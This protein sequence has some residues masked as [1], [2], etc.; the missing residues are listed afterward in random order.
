MGITHVL[1]GEEWLPSLPLH[2]DLYAHLNLTP[3]DFAHIPILLNPDGSKMSKRNGDVRVV[4]YIVSC[5]SLPLSFFRVIS[6]FIALF[7][8]YSAVVGNLKLS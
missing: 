3:P 2:L 8:V 1:R 4:D 7:C 6:L 5:P